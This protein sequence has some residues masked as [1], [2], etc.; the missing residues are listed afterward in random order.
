MMS[1]FGAANILSRLRVQ[2]SAC[3][4]ALLVDSNGRVVRDPDNQAT[5][6]GFVIPVLNGSTMG[7]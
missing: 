5:T 4:E 3:Q 2:N 6:N 1:I 7:H